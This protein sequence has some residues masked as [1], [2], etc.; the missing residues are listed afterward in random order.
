MSYTHYWKS[1]PHRCLKASQ[2]KILSQQVKQII[3]RAKLPDYS[4]K[5]NVHNL[6]PKLISFNGWKPNEEDHET[7]HLD[8]NEENTDFQFCKTARKPYDT[9]VTAT[10]IAAH[11]MSKG[12]IKISSDG[13]AE[14][15]LK[16]FILLARA[17]PEALTGQEIILGEEPLT[18]GL[19]D[20][21]MQIV[22][23][24][25][26]PSPIALPVNAFVKV[27]AIGGLMRVGSS[28]ILPLLKAQDIP[29]FSIHSVLHQVLDTI[30]TLETIKW[31][32]STSDREH[33]IEV[34]THTLVPLFGRHLFIRQAYKQAIASGKS[35]VAIEF[36]D[37]I[38]YEALEA[39]VIGDNTQGNACTLLPVSSSV[40]VELAGISFCELPTS[41]ILLR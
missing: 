35:V 24:M 31:S 21:V 10:L 15:W 27:L 40:E 13:D 28:S 25:L 16:G 22:E 7:F 3:E 29:T 19:S 39:L 12:K 32:S 5:I 6:T 41:D 9:V 18:F 33:C 14:D 2:F 30:T 38:E 11:L 34:A 26:T 1:K 20:D 17:C 37:A 8:Y 23:Q 4:I 36:V